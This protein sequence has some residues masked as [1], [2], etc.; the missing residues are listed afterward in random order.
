M[1][2]YSSRTPVKVTTNVWPV[3]AGKDTGT[4]VTAL[5]TVLSAIG[6]SVTL[7]TCVP[8]AMVMEVGTEWRPSATTCMVRL[9]RVWGLV[10]L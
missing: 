3:S 8:D 1:A 5:G 10:R 6:G 9:V 4:V 7:R 2:A